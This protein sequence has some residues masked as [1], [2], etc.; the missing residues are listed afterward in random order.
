MRRPSFLWHYTDI[1]GLLGI[2]REGVLRFS[3][4]RFLND[5]TEQAYGRDVIKKVL[6]EEA[7]AVAEMYPGKDE[8]PT[9]LTL[10][11]GMLDPGALGSRLYL[12]S[13]TEEPDSISQWQ[14][15]GADG[16]GYCLGFQSGKLTFDRSVGLVKMVYAPSHQ[17]QLLG[18]HIHQFIRALLAGRYDGLLARFASKNRTPHTAA[19]LAMAIEPLALRLKNPKFK[20]E[21]EWRLIVTIDAKESIDER[22]EFAARDNYP[23]P[24]VPMRLLDPGSKLPIRAVVCGPRLESVLARSAVHHLVGAAGYIDTHVQMSDL[25]STWR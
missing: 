19:L 21:R 5:R 15:Y 6:A 22:V 12:C 10:A 8:L 9:I 4:A 25:T 11:Q 1:N 23:K 7:R 18:T 17:R 13:L 2:V 14:R 20:D 24:Y 3:D 16:R